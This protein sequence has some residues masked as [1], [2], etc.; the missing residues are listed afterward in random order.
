MFNLKEQPGRYRT[1]WAPA[2]ASGHS[3]L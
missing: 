3:V 1:A 2:G